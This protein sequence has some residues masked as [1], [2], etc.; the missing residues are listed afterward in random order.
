MS[1]YPSVR[2]IPD[3]GPPAAADHT[4]PPARGRQALKMAATGNVIAIGAT[5][6][7]T[8]LSSEMVAAVI[9]LFL[10]AQVGLGVAAFGLF[11]GAYQ[12]ATILLRLWGAGIADRTRRHKQVAVAGYGISAGARVGLALAAVAAVPAL[13]IDRVGK[14]LRA[15]PRDALISM[16]A[17]PTVTATA[18]GI[19]RTMDT[20]G[21]LGGP[22][23]AFGILAVT[24]DAFDAVFTASAMIGLAGLAVVVLTV[25]PHPP[26]TGTAGHDTPGHDTPAA[27]PS[28]LTE[29]RSVL[30]VPGLKRLA[31]TAGGLAAV[32]V[33]DAFV[34]LV[35]ADQADMDPKLFPLLFAGTALAYL[36]LAV[37]FGRAADRYGAKKV[38]LAGHA[39]LIFVYLTVAAADLTAVT[40]AV[41]V[42]VGG[43]Y[44]AATD[45]VTSALATKAAPAR[46]RAAAIAVVSV[47]VAVGRFVSSVAFGAA[48]TT[49]GPTAAFALFAAA[50][51]VALLAAAIALRPDP[52]TGT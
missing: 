30:A 3:V 24:A 15:A 17:P 37:P 23:L 19:H 47:A 34:Y 18:F 8:D 48:W 33:S 22:L 21:A 42:A 46:H 11:D 25:D 28:W 26:Y 40:V 20:I 27:K 52:A 35:I 32:S 45:G 43:A 13:L 38:F 44:W 12:A 39:A 9:P 6:L 14:G 16:S 4:T 2:N 51:A 7:I 29:T 10:T 31:V 49:W 50:L 5:S 41:V 1:M 36:S